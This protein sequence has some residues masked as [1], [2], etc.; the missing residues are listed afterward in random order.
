MKI[1]YMRLYA[2]ETFQYNR[3]VSFV[4][5]KNVDFWVCKLFAFYNSYCVGKLRQF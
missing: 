5:T 1:L 3:Q 4:N 2:N